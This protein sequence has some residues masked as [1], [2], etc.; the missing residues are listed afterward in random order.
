MILVVGATGELGG[1]IAHGLLD[2]RHAVRILV[3]DGCSY[4]QLTDAGAEAVVGDLKDA[5]S[6]QAACTGVEAVL[7]TANSVGR[8]G[9]DTIESVDRVGNRNLVDAAVAAGVRRFV[10]ISAL[11]ADP[12]SPSPFLCAKGETEERLRDSGMAWTVLRPNV[13]MDILIPAVVG[14][15]ALTGQPVMLVG[16][17][18]RQHSFVARR[19]VAA[20]A[21]AALQRQDA[22]RRTLVIAGPQP[23]SWRDIVATFARE[24]G[25][26][27]PIR[28]V[29]PGEPVPG[30]PEMAG[31]LLAAL[32]TYDSP[33][34]IS[35]L[36]NTYRITPTTVADFAHDFI[37]T[38]QPAALR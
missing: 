22:Q 14:Y 4:D 5:D 37:A 9:E 34:D 12:Q 27:L 2:R 1:L 29:S 18:H 31:D 35:T 11:G 6:L 25:R 17:G 28:T 20:Y 30:L 16:A 26:E 10:F 33:I 15:P 38:S 21:L 13:F 24:L 19:D 23:V 7:T 3:R 36:S 8:G 32:D